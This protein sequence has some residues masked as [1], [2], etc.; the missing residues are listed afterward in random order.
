MYIVGD[1][2]YTAIYNNK[3]I[4]LSKCSKD[5]IKELKQ[6]NETY[7]C[8]ECQGT[9]RLKMGE[10]KS[11]HFSHITPCCSTTKLES[12]WHQKGKKLMYEWACTLNP[13]KIELEYYIKSIKRTADLMFEVDHKQYV[14]EIQKSLIPSREIEQRTQDYESANF[15]PIWIFIVP[16]THKKLTTYMP[17]LMQRQKQHVMNHLDVQKKLLMIYN[18]C[19]WLSGSECI[20][21]NKSRVLN[22]VALH[23]LCNMNL[24]TLEISRTHWLDIKKQFRL[25]KWY[26]YSKR[27]WAL[28]QLVMKHRMSYSLINAEVG[29]PIVQHGGFVE[30]LF[31]WQSIVWCCLAEYEL[32]ECFSSSELLY[33][34]CY[35]TSASKKQK[36]KSLLMELTQYLKVL[37]VSGCVKQVEG[38]YVR[39][40]RNK[41]YHV[42]EDAI[43]A[44]EILS[45]KLSCFKEEE[46]ALK[47]I[48]L[49]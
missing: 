16:L 45:K 30:P 10:I 3:L 8:P 18:A 39:V 20:S 31:V 11:P 32:G 4:E 40:H 43:K 27:H 24:E 7:Y 23:E 5:E 28:R 17:P 36:R 2:M 19:L 15:V 48:P 35:Y 44:D 47:M 33:R 9:V 46:R 21:S 22:E 37:V 1:M 13:S 49:A 25:R 41:S 29:W 34:V 38:Y 12:E 42:L 6:K 14:I 26:Y